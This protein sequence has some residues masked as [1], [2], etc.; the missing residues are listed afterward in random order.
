[1]NGIFETGLV[2]EGWHF[3]I[4]FLIQIGFM[5]GCLSGDNMVVERKGTISLVDSEKMKRIPI[6]RKKK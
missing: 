2:P 5:L 4:K 3:G 1:M 6:R